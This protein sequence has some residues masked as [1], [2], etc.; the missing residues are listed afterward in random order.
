MNLDPAETLCA[1]SATAEVVR[2]Y[3]LAGRKVPAG[4]GELYRRLELEVACAAEDTGDS[5]TDLIGVREAAR[6][7]HCSER[8]VRRRATELGGVRLANWTWVFSR[9]ALMSESGRIS[10]S[11]PHI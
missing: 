4:I 11:V 5:T 10:R 6:L 8:H 3:R 2:R 9:S 1:Y 7:L